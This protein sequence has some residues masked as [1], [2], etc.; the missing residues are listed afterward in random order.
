[1]T[2]CDTARLAS[3][4]HPSTYLFAAQYYVHMYICTYVRLYIHAEYGPVY[5]TKITVRDYIDGTGGVLVACEMEIDRRTLNMHWHIRTYVGGCKSCL[6]FLDCG[7]YIVLFDFA[8][9]VKVLYST[10]PFP[11]SVIQI[12]FY[13][14]SLM[15]P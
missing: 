9:A 5:S 8:A 7:F 1:M 2:V 13:A 4:I 12:F 14:T 10:E 15:T 11:K 6:S 3:S